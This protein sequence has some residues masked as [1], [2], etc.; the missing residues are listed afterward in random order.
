MNLWP[1]RASS[2]K[3]LKTLGS[4]VCERIMTP[5]KWLISLS[6]FYPLHQ[7]TFGKSKRS[8]KKYILSTIP[9]V[10]CVKGKFLGLYLYLA[11]NECYSRK[12]FIYRWLC[13]FCVSNPRMRAKIFFSLENT[14]FYQ[15]LWTWN[16][17][18]KWLQ[19]L[20]ITIVSD[21]GKF[22]C[23]HTGNIWTGHHS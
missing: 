12:D 15:N 23:Q 4:S 18:G 8:H 19:I 21:Q 10:W 17:Y 22:F 11:G 5:T 9:N 7:I 1:S 13:V 16:I 3:S 2:I 6:E 14:S 20:T